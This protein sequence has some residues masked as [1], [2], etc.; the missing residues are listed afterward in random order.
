MPG[1]L[2]DKFKF[3]LVSEVPEML[4][5]TSKNPTPVTDTLNSSKKSKSLVVVARVGLDM[6]C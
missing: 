4:R 3:S 6:S 2:L 1:T 5:D